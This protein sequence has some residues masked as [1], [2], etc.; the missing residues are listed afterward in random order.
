MGV[1]Y[2]AFDAR[3][4][5]RVALKTL[6]RM[7]PVSLYRF[8]QE[9][10]SLVDV[11]H[12][13][14]VGLYELVSDGRQ[15]FFTMELV[16][17]VPF[18][19]HVRP[20]G[21]VVAAP[22]QLDRLRAALRQLAEGV[23][24][25]HQA[26]K[27]HRDIKPGN[28]LVTPAGRVVL[29]D[30]GLAA[31]LDQAGLHHS[32]DDC[33]LG[34]IAYMAPEQ[35]A[36]QPVSLASDWYSFGVLLYEALTGRLPFR[37][38]PLQVLQDKQ[39]HEPVAPGDLVAGLPEDLASL[40]VELLRRDHAARPA[41][42]DVLRRLGS[43]A[44]P[45]VEPGRQAG[46]AA[47]IGR[48]Q[49]LDLLKGAFQATRKGRTV[50][51]YLRG[52]SGAGK[53][54]LVQAFL[55]GLRTTDQAVILAGRCH[56]QES[57]PYK[58]VDGM[59]DALSRYLKGLPSQEAEVLLPRDVHSLARTFPVLRQVEP[60][61][62]TARSLV[63]TPDPQQLRRQ[64]FAALRE[65]LGRLGD[66]RPLVLAVDDLHWGDLDSTALL[67]ELFRPPDPP[68]LLFLGTYRS[69][70]ETK[71]YVQTLLQGDCG[72]LADTAPPLERLVLD[73][74][75][76]PPAEARELA[77][78]L[79]GPGEAAR[80]ESIARESGGNP[81]FV[82]ELAHALRAGGPAAGE[83]RLDEVLWS[84]VREL[85]S[86]ARRLLAVVAVAG[87]PV[88][89]AEASQAAEV[90]SGV[91][92]LVACLRSARLL[93][94][95]GSAGEAELETYHDRVRE[96]VQARLA[97]AERQGH[98]HRLALALEASGRADP[99]VLA[100][101]FQEAGLPGHAAAYHH[102]AADQAATALAFDRAA[103]LYRLAL[104]GT[105][106]G[107]GQRLLRVKFA[108]ALANAGRGTEAGQEYL[109]AASGADQAEGV[110]C[111][112]RAALQ[113]LISGQ[114]EEG[115]AAMRAV[116]GAIGMRLPA[117][118]RQVLLAL[119]AARG[120][121]WLR[122]LRFRERAADAVPAE[123]LTR[124][125]ICWSAGVGLSVMDPVPGS[126]F[127][128]RSLLLALRAGEPYRIARALAC[129]AAYVAMA[130]GP[131]RRRTER[132]LAAVAAYAGRTGNAHARGLLNLV[133]GMAAYFQGRW[134]DA[135][136]SFGQ[137]EAI[138]RQE[139][140]GVWWELDTAQLFSLYVTQF[141]D[142]AGLAQRVAAVLK[143]ARERG[144]LYASVHA[145][146]NGSPFARL[147]AG[148]PDGARRE[149]TEWLARWPAQRFSLQHFHALLIHTQIDLYTGQGL[150]AWQR[151]T[152]QWPDLARSLLLSVQ[153]I[154]AWMRYLRGS[155]A[156]A[157][158]AGTTRN[159]HLWR[160][161]ARDARRLR[162]ERMPWAEA[163]AQLLEAGVAGVRGDRTGAVRRLAAAAAA[164]E[165]VELG[166]FAAAARRRRG[167]LLG[168]DEGRVLLAHADAWMQERH[169]A[170]PAR[171]TAMVAPGFP[172]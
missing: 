165:G 148:D 105:P 88:G 67:S 139:C 56:E 63:Q 11:S 84:R 83:V 14:L 34:T 43:Q 3:R 156:L 115:L 114:G 47:L 37:G 119:L 68:V 32:A 75:V 80:A 171:I 82:H 1:V 144:D 91:R 36:S 99:E 117:T 87:R 79:L 138:L 46:A 48:R 73:V 31:E 136:A 151:I 152:S 61:A 10:R 116:L 64:A 137:A 35:A 33:V 104:D 126:V 66:R 21:P 4:Q 70:A 113:L 89:Q 135:L 81:F 76:L 155:G 153:V 78:G 107:A 50:L 60:L 103:R 90:V 71:P 172:V 149:V 154:R 122:G 108:D 55:G 54:A 111:R 150:P 132:Q 93:R 147:L 53:T 5:E 2:L 16:E 59:V 12:P 124:I 142:P 9:F 161:A 69:E 94:G 40:C 52:G 112:R 72:T 168:G 121:L 86:E 110:E 19:D 123:E 97:P 8:K 106:A 131:A 158:A 169:I 29:L 20:A 26:G 164:L 146:T 49:H 141:I 127:Q 166:V 41:G 74:E 57:G 77:L 170:D 159:R 167:E 85:P 125:D 118:P 163:L 24:A 58:A 23:A 51:V 96:T 128:T 98:H 22:A 28:V 27:L 7:D 133:A 18:L 101:H 15:W 160:E 140:T 13:N 6:S 157:A 109:A 143:E 134:R 17:G 65:L 25:L 102:Q 130:G 39:A 92:G 45:R 162:R 38:P 95:T 129:N 30:F 62:R 100:G 145:G 42:P 120:L 44:V